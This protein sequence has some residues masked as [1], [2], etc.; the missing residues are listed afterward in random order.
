MKLGA[1]TEYDSQKVGLAEC[2]LL[3]HWGAAV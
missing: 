2:A 1:Y 3:T